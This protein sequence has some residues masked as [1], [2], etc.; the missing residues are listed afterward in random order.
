[1]KTYLGQCVASVREEVRSG[2]LDVEVIVVDNG[3][4]DSSEEYIRA[5]FPEVKYIPLE[6]NVG[7][8]KAFNIGLEEAKGEYIL[9][10]DSDTKLLPNS[11]KSLAALLD[12]DASGVIGTAVPKLLNGDGTIQFSI[13]RDFPK[14]SNMLLS[15]MGVNAL[16]EKKWPDVMY[17]GRQTYPL[18]AYSHS[19]EITFAPGACYLI[20]RSVFDRIGPLDESFF[21][22]YDDTDFCV[23][24][25]RAG[26]KMWYDATSH[27]IHYG[28]KSIP[29]SFKRLKVSN[30]SFRKYFE[31]H[32]GRPYLLA[33]LIMQV[34]L[35]V[36]VVPIQLIGYAIMRAFRYRANG[37][38]NLILSNVYRGYLL[39]LGEVRRH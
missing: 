8:A 31:K 11:V 1:M 20:R 13:C 39:V 6:K 23:R 27:V 14:L 36:L 17:W 33:I 29:G 5:N 7:F 26:F 19:R 32:H 18:S 34:I 3:S 9:K 15:A 2:D 21:V 10:I 28:G 38:R 25:R 16:M 12:N 24:A 4:E 22:Q 35:I 30:G 37:L